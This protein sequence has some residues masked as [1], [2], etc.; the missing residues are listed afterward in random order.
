MR[1]HLSDCWQESSSEAEHGGAGGFTDTGFF[2]LSLAKRA[3]AG[4]LGVPTSIT[5]V[6]GFS[7]IQAHLEDRTS[8]RQYVCVCWTRTKN[9]MNVE[10]KKNALSPSNKFVFLTGAGGVGLV[11]AVAAVVGSVAQPTFG[12]AAVVAAFEVI[13]RAAVIVCEELKNGE[14]ENRSHFSLVK[15]FSTHGAKSNDRKTKQN[16]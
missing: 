14:R 12:D 4:E 6:S 13:S 7:R 8:S 1:K 10:S 16:L 11:L 5:Q 9:V 15:S 3:L 2:S